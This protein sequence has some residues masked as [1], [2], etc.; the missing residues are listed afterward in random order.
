MRKVFLSRPNWIADS[1]QSGM[2]AFGNVLAD[3]KLAPQTVGVTHHPQG[4]PMDAVIEVMDQCS[5]AIVLGLPQIEVLSGHIKQHSISSPLSLATEWNHIEAGLAYARGLPLLVIH[6]ASVKRGV[7]DRGALN[8]FLYEV[9][10]TS[11]SWATL[12]PVHAALR[13]WKLSMTR[14]GKKPRRSGT[15]A[16]RTKSVAR[17]PGAPSRLT[18]EE[19]D[20]LLCVA[21]YDDILSNDCALAV[22]LSKPKVDHL[23]DGLGEANLI[24]MSRNARGMSCRITPAGR[25]ALAEHG[26]I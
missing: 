3:L 12:D 6:D 15:S 10:T 1:Y 14:T 25:S 9:D 13:E 17:Q 26:K 22:R 11:A 20:V 19:L 16:T 2:I 24:E 21:N 5:G 7:F 8:K 18:E 4:S 23:L